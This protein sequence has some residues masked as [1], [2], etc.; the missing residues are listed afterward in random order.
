M[1]RLVAILAA[2]VVGFSALMSRD[3]EGTLKRLIEL[4]EQ[5]FEPAVIRHNGRIFKLAGDGALTEFASV[6]DAVSCAIAL[7]TALAE[8]PQFGMQL[9]LGV[10][11]GDIIVQGR[12]IYGDGVNIA[13]RLETLAEPGGICISGIVKNSVGS[14][15]SAHFEDAGL[16]EL[17]NIAEPVHVFRWRP[18]GAAIP[19]PESERGV[20]A[21]PAGRA[22]IAVLA[23]DNMST[24]PEQEYFSD[25]IAEDIITALSHFR[26]FFVIARNTTFAFKG[27]PVRVDRICREL[28]VRYLLEGSVRKAGGKV[29][30]TAQLI[31]GET[32]AHIWAARYDRAMDDIFAV[33]DE[34]TQAIVGAAAPETLIAET[35][36][37]RAQRPD[38]LSAW[39]KLL[40]ARWHLGKFTQ[41][42]NTAARELLTEAAASDPDN[43]D[44]HAAMSL[45]DLIAMLHVWRTD[46]VV[47]IATARQTAESAVA[48]DDSNA[49]AHGMLGMACLFARDFDAGERHLGRATDLNPNLA[50]GHGNFA[51]FH[52][53]CGDFQAAHEAFER[54][55]ALSPR[56]P[57]LAFWRGGY[58]IGAF[59]TGAYETCLENARAGLRETPGYASL[60]RQET[61]SL[62]M[63]DRMDDARNAL[64]RLLEQMPGLTVGQVR[65]I[66]P[67]RNPDDQEIWLD[68]LRR[69]GL[70]D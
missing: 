70:P 15:V 46:T 67:F 63:L 40:R 52:G 18:E 47:A 42:E 31:D 60:L 16:H 65:G 17:R 30:V 4:R 12:D 61:A 56:D 48:L 37:A 49:N 32:G 54:A 51:A 14:R 38:T 64:R 26:D 66:V 62:A 45:C 53:V 21:V 43:S 2:D 20:E 39:D 69:A 24:D 25:G 6:V 27:Q 50:I 1:R 36:R 19:A 29:R 9:R 59:N 22:S 58:G 13:A 23:F 10:N 11:L 8:V 44:I 57:L 41:A 55:R 35:R 34:I 68:A 33:Q 28:G 7:Q 3:E 5:Y